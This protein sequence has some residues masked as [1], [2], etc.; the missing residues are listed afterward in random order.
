MPEKPQEPAIAGSCCIVMCVL[1]TLAQCHSVGLYGR[2]CARYARTMPCGSVVSRFVS[3]ALFGLSARRLRPRVRAGVTPRTLWRLGCGVLVRV[4]YQLTLRLAGRVS[5]VG[6]HSLRSGRTTRA[7]FRT[8]RINA[9]RV[10][11]AAWARADCPR[12]VIRR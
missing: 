12:G 2:V 3:G 7:T 5:R 9:V 6:V 10:L 11:G 8:M 1:A 4:S